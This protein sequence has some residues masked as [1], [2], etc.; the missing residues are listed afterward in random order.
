M[1]TKRV[2]QHDSKDN[3]NR[4]VDM[5]MHRKQLHLVLYAGAIRTTDYFRKVRARD[6]MWKA[7]PV[8]QACHQRGARVQDV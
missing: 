1:R 5:T 3:I 8:E 2:T 4:Y 7:D 6:E